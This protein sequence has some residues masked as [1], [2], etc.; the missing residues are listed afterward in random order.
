LFADNTSILISDPNWQNLNIKANQLFYGVNLWFNSNL[1]TL[2]YKKTYYIEYRTKNYYKIRTDIQYEG[3]TIPNHR[4]T[5]F[6]G[7]IMDET[8]TWN[9][10]IDSAAKKLCTASYV[11]RNLKHIVSP[12]T[13]KTLY[14][15]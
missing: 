2:N 6:L 4:S 15:A 1:L 12:T 11:I 10:H 9:E 8:L 14:C 7:I 5:K 3:N 13:L